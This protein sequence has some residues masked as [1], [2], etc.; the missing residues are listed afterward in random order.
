[1]P[2]VKIIKPPMIKSDVLCAAPA[3]PLNKNNEPANETAIPN[4]TDA[5][6]FSVPKAAAIKAITMGWVEMMMPPMPAL[7]CAKPKMVPRK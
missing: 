2:H 3:S 5:E 6:S 1:M 4:K 7:T